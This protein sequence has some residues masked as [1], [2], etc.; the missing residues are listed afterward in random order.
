MNFPPTSEA[1]SLPAGLQ[2]AYAAAR[3]KA[4][5]L[6]QALPG[7]PPGRRRGDH[8]IPPALLESLP[9]IDTMYLESSSIFT[10]YPA[11]PTE[12]QSGALINAAA[13]LQWV[14]RTW[15]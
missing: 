6:H 12:P 4:S 7:P 11:A 5:R 13:L 3:K 15:L 9:L 1:A 14:Q 10:S 2:R 8:E